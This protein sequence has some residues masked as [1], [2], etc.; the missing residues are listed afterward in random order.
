M[1]S[2]HESNSLSVIFSHAFLYLLRALPTGE[3]LR[4]SPQA[5]AAVELP[6]LSVPGEFTPKGDDL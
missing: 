2:V 4:W 3:C 5:L 6:V 1:R